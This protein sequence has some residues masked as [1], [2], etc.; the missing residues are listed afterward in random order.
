MMTSGRTKFK[1]LNKFKLIL[2]EKKV[3]I[4]KCYLKAKF[5]KNI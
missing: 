2:G 5:P 3:K 1:E 4:Q